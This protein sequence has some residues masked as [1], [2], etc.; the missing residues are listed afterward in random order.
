MIKVHATKKNVHIHTWQFNSCKTS[1]SKQIYNNKKIKISRK[2][3]SYPM[4]IQG[5][6]RKE[7]SI[8]NNIHTR[9]EKIYNFISIRTVDLYIPHEI[10]HTTH[11]YPK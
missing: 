8:S 10:L 11:E 6:I 7:Y 1:I 4:P 9:I 5:E 2:E 3:D